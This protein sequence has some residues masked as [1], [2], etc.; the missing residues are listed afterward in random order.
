MLFVSFQSISLSAELDDNKTAS[1]SFLS[2][3]IVVHASL[4]L[5]AE[6]GF[7]IFSSIDF[8]ALAHTHLWAAFAISKRASSVK[9]MS[10]LFS[11]ISF[12][13]LEISDHFFFIISKS[14]ST[15]NRFK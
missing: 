13:I 3:V 6:I 10:I 4:I 11:D 2:I 15:L 1:T 5:F 8:I 7:I 14:C 9:L 12:I